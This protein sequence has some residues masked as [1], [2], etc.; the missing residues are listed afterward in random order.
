MLYFLYGSDTYRL[1]EKAGE[2]EK[3]YLKV[4]QGVLN[5]EKFDA[6]SITFRD[7]WEAL[8]QRSMFVEKKLFFVENIFATD[9]FA[10]EFVKKVKEL[11]ESPDIVVVLE[12]KELKTK[13]GG[14]LFKDLIKQSNVQEFKKMD[15]PRLKV[16]IKKEASRR[17]AAIED[18]AVGALIS[19]A[20][21]DLWCLHNELQK[22]ASHSKNIREEGVRLLVKPKIETEI[23][24]TIDALAQRDKVMALR[25]LQKHLDK[26]DSPFY[27]FSMFV[28]QFRNLLA[29]KAAEGNPERLRKLK[30]HPFVL[31]KTSSQASRFS[32]A[33][34]KK[35]YQKIFNLDLAM[36]T[37][38]IIADD[39]LRMMIAEI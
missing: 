5:L 13:E 33:E 8:S 12:R 15:G 10:G 6:K 37:G 36:K 7:F 27:V 3:Q 23:F 25:L 28:Y 16:W 22:L 29:V 34:L 39:G 30:L 2:I 9:A 38:K 31:K 14:R 20:G 4:N 11:S 32:L 26:G 17:G 21:G 1:Q 24:Q 19:F 35:N 18:S